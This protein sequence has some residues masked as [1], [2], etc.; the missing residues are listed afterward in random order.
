MQNKHRQEYIKEMNEARELMTSDVLEHV[1]LLVK[2]YRQAKKH[3]NV[4]CLIYTGGNIRPR[5]AADFIL[6]QGLPDRLIVDIHTEEIDVCARFFPYYG[7]IPI[8][9]NDLAREVLAANRD[10]SNWSSLSAITV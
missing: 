5:A 8:Y 3:C 4:N 9:L 7:A 1:D 10:P 6:S 2:A